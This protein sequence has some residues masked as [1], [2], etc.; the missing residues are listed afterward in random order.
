VSTKYYFAYGANMS[1][2]SM[3]QRCPLAI[4]LKKFYLKDHRLDFAGHATVVPQSGVEC[5]GALWLITETCEASLDQF[6]GY[7]TY[8][9]KE[10]LHQDG[11]DIMVYVMNDPDFA[12]APH[13]SYLDLLEQGRRDW[14][15][16]E[17]LGFNVFSN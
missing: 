5:P 7:P 13:Q 16:S 9:R 17:D 8:Y 11:V 6:E 15:L 14:Q 4:P 1:L 10:Y 3:S 2:A 12:W